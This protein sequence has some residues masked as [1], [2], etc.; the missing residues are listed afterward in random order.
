MRP[1]TPDSDA[2]VVIRPPTPPPPPRRGRWLAVAVVAVVVLAGAGGAAWLLRPHPAPPPPAPVAHAPATPAPVAT[3][4]PPPAPA[5]A[6]APPPPPAPAPAPFS[7]VTADEATIAAHVA[8]TLSL[9]RFA[10][11]P[12][13]V[14]LDFPTLAEQG[15]MLNR[16]AAL[17]EKA[18][19]P[20][21]RVLTDAELAAAIHASGDTPETYYYG[22]DY[23]AAEL[24]RFFTLADRDHVA[25]NAEEAKLRALLTQLGWFAPDAVGA[26]ISVPAVGADAFVTP[27]AREAM[28]HHELSHGIFFSNPAYADYVRKFW[29]TVL[30]E[31]ERANVRSFLGS[32]DY[33]TTDEDLM[34]NEMQAYVMFTY[35]PRFCKA[36]NVGMTLARRLELIA[37]FRD[38]LPEGWPKEALE[39]PSLLPQ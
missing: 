34:L 5:P 24:A 28:L 29:K 36:V 23:S 21:D 20:R 25:L 9:F 35:D 19:L 31:Q 26:L 1:P 11:A 22:H 39:H 27:Q 3:T 17:I 18:K 6:P 4:A 15:Q 7:I 8:T 38:G 13:V 14:V 2:T 33:D 12:A 10:A 16:M 32:Q 30:T 37:K